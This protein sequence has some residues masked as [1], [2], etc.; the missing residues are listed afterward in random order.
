MSFTFAM[1]KSIIKMI[2]LEKGNSLTANSLGKFLTVLVEV[3]SLIWERRQ[4]KTN[5]HCSLKSLHTYN[6]NSKKK[7]RV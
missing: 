4:L 1:W 5:F 3:D 6:F 2:K 7:T